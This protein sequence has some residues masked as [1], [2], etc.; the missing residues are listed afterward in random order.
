MKFGLKQETLEKIN[1]VFQH[2]EQVEEVI[3]YGSRAKGNY[4]E[5]SDIDLTIK[6]KDLNIFLLNK[7]SDDLDN[8]MLPYK[9]DLSIYNYLQ[10][11]DI[12]DHI[13]KIGVNFYMRLKRKS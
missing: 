13:E 7:I 9:F 12:I 1:N 2:Y 4:K 11:L 10:N 8:L 6:G 5:G 3:L